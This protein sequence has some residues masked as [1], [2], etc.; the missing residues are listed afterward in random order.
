MATWAC[1]YCDRAGGHAGAS[2]D[3]KDLAKQFAEQHARAVAS[4]GMPLKWEDAGSSIVLTTPRGDYL[5][6]PVG[7]ATTCTTN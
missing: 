6:A 2:F 4:T 3:T 1:V 5:V 7:P